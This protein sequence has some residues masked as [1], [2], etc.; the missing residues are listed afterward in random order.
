MPPN[1]TMAPP[2]TC[3]FLFLFLS[4]TTCDLA[5]LP[6][7]EPH[8]PPIVPRAQSDM[9]KVLDMASPRSYPR[10]EV[11]SLAG[12]RVSRWVGGADHVLPRP[13]PD[14]SGFRLTLDE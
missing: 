11:V 6:H 2:K 8:S 10:L 4:S 9:I 7:H 1:L 5:P 14:R 13:G 3:V 12:R